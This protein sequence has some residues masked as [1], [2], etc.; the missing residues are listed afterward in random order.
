MQPSLNSQTL[1]QTFKQALVEVLHEEHDVLRDVFA[2][3]I[4]DLALAEAIRAGQ[5]SELVTRGA[6][7][8]VLEV[9]EV[10]EGKG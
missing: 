4:E 8:E 5:D 3:A 9:L 6:V 2:E 7:F 1:K 10:L